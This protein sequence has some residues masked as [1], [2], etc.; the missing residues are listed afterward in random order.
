MNKHFFLLLISSVLL[1]LPINLAAQETLDVTFR[2]TPNDNVVRSFVPGSFNNWGNNSSGQISASDGSLLT[3]DS[4]LGFSYQVVELEIG[5]GAFTHNGASGYTYKFH[6][7]YNQSGT[8][9][10]WFTD[11]LNPIAIGSN[12]DSFIEVTHPLIFQVE[13]TQGSIESIT[14][15]G[16]TANVAAKSDDPI[17]QSESAV[18]LNG[19]LLTNFEGFYETARQLLIIPSLDSFGQELQ[20]GANEVTILAV[21]EAGEEKEYS[22]TFTFAIPDVVDQPRPAG[23]EDGITYHDDDP[24]KV[25]LSMW[26]PGK[27]YVYVIGDFNNWQVESDYLMKRDVVDADNVH[28]WLEVDGLTPGQEYAFQYLIDGN[29][30]MAD[31]FSE[32]V[33]SPWNDQWISES[34]YPNLMPFPHDFTTEMVTV[35]QP[36]REPFEWTANDFVRPDP[37]EMVVYELLIRDFFEDETYA[38][39]AD[40]LGYLER[41]GVNAIELMPVSNFDGNDSWGYNPNFHLA[42]DKAYGPAH[43][44][45]RFI[46]EAHSRGIAVILDVVYNHATGQSP[47]V[48]LY[49][50]STSTNPL[51]GNGHEFN[52]FHHLNHNHPY[53]QYWMDRANRHWVE[54]FRID[55]Y[56]FDLTKGFANN[57]SGNNY[58]GYN[59]QRIANLKR[60]A[61]AL[62]EVDPDVYIILEHFTDNSEEQEL[63]HHRRDEGKQGMLFWGN[64]N[65]Q[66]NEASMGYHS[67]NQSNFTGVYHGSRGWAAP[68]LVGFM[69]SHDEQWLMFKNLNFGNREGSYDIR[70]LPFALDRQKLVGAFFFTLPGP[71]MMWQFGELGYGGGPNECLKP[72]GDDGDC[73][74]SDPGRTDRKPIRWDYYDD[75]DRQLLYQTWKWLLKARNENPV[76]RSPETNVQFFDMSSAHKVIRLTHPTMTA[77]L[78]GN[79]GV[80]NAEIDPRFPSSG[81]WYDYFSGESWEIEPG[82]ENNRILISPG[83]FHI[84][85]TELLETPPPGLIGT[86]IN[87]DDRFSDM[88]GEFKL[89]QNYPNPFNPTTSIRFDVAEASHFTLSVYNILGQQVATLINEQRNA[90]S[91][92][93]NFDASRLSSGTYFVRM[94]ANGQVFT[95]KMMLI[96]QVVFG[97]T[98]TLRHKVLM[99]QCSFWIILRHQG[100]QFPGAFFIIISS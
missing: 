97:T 14:P 87:E 22:V 79:F 12:N 9:W 56:R 50:S 54:R 19:T 73:L 60:M 99:Y 47:L 86:S 42:L 21:T 94:Q 85:T 89:H 29:L 1:I 72:G 28:F 62:W 17:D 63:A 67:G 44:F 100:S 8:N 10:Q 57:F 91:Y 3:E 93:V 35:I 83:Q 4:E 80:T 75:P 45:K 34:T 15:P 69:E 68:N 64:M 36:G 98:K 38:N 53:I 52:V 46:N 84:F 88:P 41:L 51:L 95:N 78:V 92:S 7:H 31:L 24:T 82:Q 18:F 49:G 43:E 76:F 13:P 48:R 71:K 32:K 25:T 59:A 30:R 81:T 20:A 70:E 77:V 65:H 58:H 16:V 90:G 37:S 6:E 2:Y 96:K 27:E 5:G 74:P 26:A 66:Y 40:T 55:G 39:L 23:I 61:D 11:P 33:L